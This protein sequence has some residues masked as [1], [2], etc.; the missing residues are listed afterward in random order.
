MRPQILVLFWEIQI[1][2]PNTQ[3]WVTFFVGLAR[4]FCIWYL[5]FTNLTQLITFG[6]WTGVLCWLTSHLPNTQTQIRF[7]FRFASCF[8]I[9]YLDCHGLPKGDCIWY[10]GGQQF[11][12]NLHGFSL[13]GI[14]IRAT[15][16]N[17]IAFGIW[18]DASLFLFCIFVSVFGI[19]IVA[20]FKKL[21][22]YGIWTDGR[23]YGESGSQ[24]ATLPEDAKSHRSYTNSQFFIKIC[25]FQKMYFFEGVRVS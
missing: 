24:N 9:W 23:W 18:T 22:A 8:L 3:N 5:D 7:F 4:F 21:I 19:W 15:F 17:P 16:E 11:F 12:W 14:Q 13:F 10:L 1:H 2:L 20:S 25:C 6:I